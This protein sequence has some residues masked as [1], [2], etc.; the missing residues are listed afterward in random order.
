MRPACFAKLHDASNPVCKTCAVFFSC[1]VAAAKAPPGH[2]DEIGHILRSPRER[3]NK[4]P[5]G[6]CSWAACRAANLKNEPFT[7]KEILPL[8]IGICHANGIDPGSAERNIKAVMQ[9]M[10]DQGLLKR[11]KRISLTHVDQQGLH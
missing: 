6:T 7:Q 3:D 11:K 4:Y 8:Y 1:A 5:P 10:V 2:L 9:Q